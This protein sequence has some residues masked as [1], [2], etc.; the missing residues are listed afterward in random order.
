MLENYQQELHPIFSAIALGNME[1]IKGII[2]K[3]PSVLRKTNSNGYTPIFSAIHSR[4]TEA[5]KNI[6]KENPLVLKQI[7]QYRYTP[8]FYAIRFNNLEIF[9]AIIKKDRS[10]LNQKDPDGDAPIFLAIIRKNPKIVEM[11]IKENP[12]VL[13]QIDRNGNTPISLAI[14]RKNPKIVE[15]IIKENPW[16]LK[17]IDRNG[18]TPISLATSISC[19][20][21]RYKKTKKSE[22]LKIIL[23][24]QFQ[25]NITEGAQDDLEEL[26]LQKSLL[27]CLYSDEHIP[28]WLNG[29]KKTFDKNAPENTLGAIYKELFEKVDE[30]KS[31]DV[32]DN[33]KMFIFE[34]HLTQ[35]QSFFI[36][37]VSKDNKLTSISYCDGNSVSEERKIKGSETHINGVTTFHLKTPIEYN[38]D[39]A[40]NFI[41]ENTQNKST[42]YFRQKFKNQEIKGAD[43]DYSRTTHSIPT[44]IQK[45]GNCVLKST[46]VVVR[47]IFKKLYPTKEFGFD[48]K[49]KKPTGDGYDTYKEFK[50]GLTKNTLDSTIKI[51]ENISSKSDPLSEY[52]KKEIEDAMKIAMEYNTKKLSENDYSRKEFHRAIKNVLS[53]YEKETPRSSC[54][55]FFRSCFT[56]KNTSPQP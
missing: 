4:K 55:P 32:G 46:S 18:N 16:V 14:I 36:F 23:Q 21:S 41:E 24:N 38:N 5:V 12:L 22:V 37:H 3:D 13:K 1:E 11:I 10:V 7:D 31:I 56:L 54:F 49:T 44:K 52:L 9:E 25:E 47:E 30:N 33:E 6:I 51:K 53:G 42:E 48:E 28:F 45:R 2:K 35:H 17:Q 15:M 43:I 39:F 19:G 26:F 20:Y 27:K 50:D 40:Q 34:S 29:L 8:I